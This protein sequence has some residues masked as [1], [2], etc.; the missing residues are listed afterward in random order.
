MVGLPTHARFLHRRSAQLSGGEAQKL[1][2][3]RGLILQPRYLVADEPTAAL[4]LLSKSH[5]LRCFDR[6]KKEQGIALI[7]FTHDLAATRHIADQV[8]C[9]Q[10]GRFHPVASL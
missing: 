7:V 2:I 5:I 6:L 10:D 8:V 3:A 4:D 9:L 1:V